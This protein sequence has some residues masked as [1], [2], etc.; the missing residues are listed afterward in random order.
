MKYLTKVV[1]TY[2]V[3]SENEAAK[4]I[5]EAKQDR[6]FVLVKYEATHKEKKS[7]G[8]VIDE[9]VRVTLYKSFNDEAQPDAYIK[10][11]Y[12]REAGFFPETEEDNED[13]V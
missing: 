5:E 10:V 7:K 4:I 2:W 13:E 1:E 9:W 3:A 6:K 12:D 8:E 11:T